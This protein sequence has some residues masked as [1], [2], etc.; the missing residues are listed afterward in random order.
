MAVVG[1]ELDEL[2]D[3]EKEVAISFVRFLAYELALN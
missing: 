1:L 3:G 2:W